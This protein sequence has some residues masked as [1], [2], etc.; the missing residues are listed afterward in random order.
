[1]YSCDILLSSP[2]SARS[3][4]CSGNNLAF[5]AGLLLVTDKDYQNGEEHNSDYLLKADD[6]SLHQLLFSNI[7]GMPQEKYGS[8]AHIR[9]KTKG[10]PVKS[11]RKLRGLAP[12]AVPVLD[13]EAF[14]VLEYDSASSD[15]SSS[16]GPDSSNDKY[17]A[18]AANSSKGSTAEAAEYQPA[19]KRPIADKITTVVFIVDMC[20][21]GGGPAA[22]VE[23]SMASMAGHHKKGVVASHSKLELGT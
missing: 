5:L 6:G 20:G 12:Q 1:M 11:A 8:G 13:I 4:L 2:S 21:L 14:E 17:A 18:L 23:V 7:S 3:Q 15:S 22:T 9:V 19:S 10:Q 16:Q